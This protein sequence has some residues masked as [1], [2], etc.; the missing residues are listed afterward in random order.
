MS[1][2]I[3][4]NVDLACYYATKHSWRGKYKRLFA[5]GTKAVTTYNPNSLEITNQWSYNDFAGILP[6]N[7]SKNQ[8]EFVISLRKLG[9]KNETMKFSCD[10]RERVI[11]ETLRHCKFGSD[12]YHKIKQF[13]ARKHHWSDSQ[14]SVLLEVHAASIR[15]V[16]PATKRILSTYDYMDIEFFASVSDLPGGVVIINKF[17]R[18]H[19]FACAQ[20]KELTEA[21]FEAAVRNVGNRTMRRKQQPLTIDQFHRYKFG[22]YS[23]DVHITSLA[24]FTVQKIA[25]KHDDPVRRTLCLT[26]TCILERDPATYSIVTLR[27]QSEIFSLVR[28]PKNPQL[29]TIE[30]CRGGNRQYLSTNRDSLLATLLDG[31]RASGNRDVCVKSVPTNLGQRLGP[32]DVHMDE[33]VESM[34]LKFFTQPPNGNFNEAIS[35]FNSC[36]QYSGLLWTVKQDG[37]FSENKEKL[38][39]QALSA[40]MQHNDNEKN[41]TDEQLELKF[42][43]LRRLVASKAG[44]AAFTGLPGFREN[45]GVMVIKALKRN[46]DSVSHAAIDVLSTLLC[47]MH[48]NHD[49]RQ[50]QLN[51]QSL[52]SSKKFLN[53]LLSMFADKVRKNCGALYISAMLDFLNFSLC[54]PY[55]E[56]TDGKS[57]DQLLQLVADLGRSFYR[58][59]Q[60]PS[61]A[62][63]KGAG[64]VMKAIIEEADSETAA[65]MQELALAE[66][67]LPLHLQT[68]MFLQSDDTRLQTNRQLSRHLVGLWV[69]GH[70]PAMTLL[71][72][73]IPAGLLSYLDSEDKVPVKETDHLNTRDNLKSAIDQS[74][75]NSQFKKIDRQ[76]K[77]IEQTVKKNTEVLIA[78]WADRMGM[79]KRE[80]ENNQQLPIVLRKAR[81]NIKTEANWALFYYQFNKDHAK[82]NLIWNHKT[83]EELR[84][85]LENQ[86]RSFH[87]IKEIGSAVEIAWNHAE[88]EMQYQCLSEEIKIGDYYLR[89]LLEE[90]LDHESL[91]IK[92]SYEFFNDLY[93]RFLLTPKVEFKCMCLQAMTIVYGKC[94]EDIGAFNDTRYIVMMLNRCKDRLE[95][96]RLLLFIE[97]LLK[98]KQ[99]VKEVIDA[100]GVKF[101]VNLVS[102]AHLHV[103]RAHVPT[104]TNVIEASQEMMS[105]M[106]GLKEWSFR[107][108][109]GER[110][111]PF[112]LKEMEEYWA[113]GVL[114]EQSRV[115][116]RDSSE[117]LMPRFVQLKWGLL[118]TGKG[119]MNETDLASTI[120][121]ML[122]TIC[123]FY[124]SRDVNDAVIRPLPRV[125]S[126]LGERQQLQ[127]VVQLLLTFDPIL[128]EKVAV[129]LMEI[130]KDNHNLSQAFLTGVFYFILM[131]NGSNVLPIGEFLKYMHLKQAFRS[132]EERQNAS[133]TVQRS[134]LGSIFPQAMVH[135]LENYGPEKF[136]EIYLGEF[137]TPEA[138][139]NAEMRRYMIEKIA[140]HIASFTPRLLANVKAT[141]TYF[142]IPIINYPQLEDELFCNIYY[143]RHLCNE[144]KFPE[145]QIKNPVPFLK[146]VL[147]MWKKEV[148]KKGSKMSYEDAYYTL[149]LNK[150]DAPFNENQIRKAY[151]KMAK[152][153]HPDKNP[154]GQEMFDE[155]HKAQALLLSSLKENKVTDGPDP[156]NILLILKTQSILFRRYKEELEPFKYAGYPALIKT[157]TSENVDDSLFK[158]DEPLL[159]CAT[160]LAYHTVNCSALNAKE[161]TRENGIEVLQTSYSRCVSMLGTMSQCD[162][163]QV[164]VCTHVSRCYTV[165]AAFEECREKFM[166]DRTVVRDLCRILNYSHLPHLCSVAV[167]CVSAFAMDVALQSVLYQQGVMWHLLIYLFNYDFTLE[168]GGV[169]K[170][171]ESNQQEVAN[172]LARL[173]VNAIACMGGF[174]HKDGDKNEM[175]MKTL[176]A[177]ITPYLTK[178][179]IAGCY[180]EVLKILNSNTQTPYLMWDN[181]TR[182]ELMEYLKDQQKQS[183]TTG[184]CDEDYGANFVYSLHQKELIVGDIF[185][186]I[187]NEQPT[188]PIEE[189]T[190]FAQALLDYLGSTAE[191]V[192]SYYALKR[193][194]SRQLARPV[195]P[196]K[197]QNHQVDLL[198]SIESADS[199][200]L[201]NQA[202]L[203][204]VFNSKA[205]VGGVIK[206][207]CLE[208]DKLKNCKLAL[209]GLSN[210]MKNYSSVQ[211]NCIGHFKMLFSFL[212]HKI[213]SD[214][215]LLALEA[216]STVVGN[217]TCVE[218]IADSS[219]LP[220]LLSVLHTLPN[221]HALAI[222]ILENLS[223]NTKIIKQIMS[224]GGLLYLLN[225]FCNDNSMESRTKVAEL[226]SKL[227][228]DKLVGPR[229]LITVTKFL[230]TIFLDAMRDSAENSVHM[231]DS[232]HEN[233][234]LMWK[235]ETR[236]MVQMTV[237]NMTQEFFT[238]QSENIEA[239]WSVPRDFIT[240]YE[241]TG[242][243]T[244]EIIVGGVYLRLF[245][246]QP[247]W[248][249]RKPREFTVD[250]LDK[251]TELIKSPKP[252][253]EVLETVTQ[254][255][256]CLF[257]AQPLQCEQVPTL[258]YLPT[259]FKCM[260]NTSNDSIPKSALSL[261]HVLSK[262][263]SCASSFSGCECVKSM[264]AAMKSRPDQIALACEAFHRIFTNNKS[265]ALMAQVIKCRL[266][267]YLLNVLDTGLHGVENVGSTRAQI[268][269]TL[270]SMTTS[271]EYGEE[272][273]KELNESTV[274]AAYKDQMHDLFI[275]NDSVAG[276]LTGGPQVAGYLTA[277]KGS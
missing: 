96:D 205:P 51:K 168:E 18:M 157:I 92:R 71:R 50:E 265:P 25:A 171:E 121:N 197:V 148:E 115:R 44:F 236:D 187:Y 65:K 117:A 132:N 137:D 113:D 36:V 34:H 128:V 156:Q 250:I 259:V 45:F 112:S 179:L 251:F 190:K 267:A 93:H 37:F 52:L 77:Q 17:G 266:V 215:R 26:E 203:S 144:T 78:H 227:L 103:S 91:I 181:A 55:S 129:L 263:E 30:Y 149:G 28:C 22:E 56:T 15:Q 264:M 136:S 94:W 274:W 224:Q 165:A 83:R 231:F 58:L 246:D 141:Y 111:G 142:P 38:I 118:A 145:W 35:R 272:I 270:K 244:Q 211:V 134:V 193:Q 73:I 66:G 151:F 253:G 40:L 277:S 3:A 20:A 242:N 268:V 198:G 273:E 252:D 248:V 239:S 82:P 164:Q 14:K 84:G 213:D 95:R 102:L 276:Y 166:Q 147:I 262:N 182:M 249:L 243:N 107:S 105:Q 39:N 155:C 210:V 131:Y 176:N 11:T 202:L 124:P 226:F 234:E 233:P 46:S 139:W 175:M 269:K 216:I 217:N 8:N 271:L 192:F 204:C 53:E 160:E 79:R 183:V 9:K 32:Q 2:I 238:K 19:M 153:Y 219:V 57:F 256:C 223:S 29:F 1:Q 68:A 140:S 130:M 116:T 201:S 110:L 64:L 258:G 221:G 222:E 241:R 162:D 150:D 59:F 47:P 186:R 208:G 10:Y 125:K 122:I 69:T 48:E 218:N 220:F 108:K 261:I 163:V 21:A 199:A 106:G 70:P 120:L 255:V 188:Y 275:A 12:S 123:R 90:D 257:A 212:Q 74:Q 62:I 89:L 247:G 173:S 207:K 24:E 143:L 260:S 104:Q 209:K 27:P 152:K 138:I 80:N 254:A 237:R 178:Q 31:V 76:L 245:I 146:D 180:A 214:I 63:V 5:V 87:Q 133:D 81:K 225:V 85:A 4:D 230:P 72:R 240:A 194:N 6:D 41:Y 195:E 97:K 100:G 159:V 191:Y 43:A 169:R 42:H 229:V 167:E 135:Y 172:R 232:E 67:A 184:R 101:L 114:T 189:P 228:S 88:F 49:M 13:N 177:L 98:H 16:H 33:D 54:Y 126:I 196:I 206:A 99:N 23:D 170:S 200:K 7:K 109:K 235:D 161:L 61:L 75:S 127:H 60:H 158:K 119:V 154:D 185:V 174:L 86:M